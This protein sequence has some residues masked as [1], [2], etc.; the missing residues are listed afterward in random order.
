MMARMLVDECGRD[1]SEPSSKSAPVVLVVDDDA[2]MRTLLEIYFSA[3]GWR[4]LLA[5]C[6]D[7][8]LQLAA[9][10]PETRLLLLDVVMSGVS[11]QDLADRSKT[12]LPNVRIFFCSGHP[13]SAL[14]GMGID[15][16]PEQF[17][18]KPC[19]PADLKQKVDALLRL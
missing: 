2:S 1:M 7:E 8:A 15:V 10:H 3:W 13:A 4:V 17:L 16:A 11:G 6:G 19:R 12:I 18:Q 5:A 14:A 9:A